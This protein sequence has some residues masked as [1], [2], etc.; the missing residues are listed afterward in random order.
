MGKLAH[1][2]AAGFWAASLL[3]AVELAAIGW[4]SPELAGVWEVQWG[5]LG[6]LPVLVTV[7][8]PLGIVG[9]LCVELL[10]RV[11]RRRARTALSLA[12]AAGACAVA[13]GV[14]GGRLLQTLASRGGFALAVGAAAGLGA[15]LAAPRVARLLGRRPALLAG[16]TA[17]AVLGLE[18]L[19][20]TVFVRRYPAFHLGLAA[21]ALAL[22]PLFARAALAFARPGPPA[23]HGA[24]AALFPAFT[25]FAFGAA[26]ATLPSGAR[27]LSGFDNFRWVLLERAPIAGKL[28]H[29]AGQWSPPAPLAE[30]SDC[31]S[32]P[33]REER[34]ALPRASSLDLSHRDVLLVTIDA[35]RADHVG[36]YGYERPTTPHIDRLAQDG[37]VF[38]Q[39]YVPTPHTSYSLT[40]LMTGKYIRPLLL[41]GAGADSD[42]WAGLLRKYGY[43]T[44]AFYPPA[45]FFIDSSRFEPFSRR[46]HDFEY[47]KVEFAEGERRVAQVRSF[48]TAETPGKRLFVWVHLFGPHEPYEAHAGHDFGTRDIDRYDSEI[49]AADATLGRLVAVARRRDPRALVIVTGDHGEEFG[50]HG[51]RYHGSSVYEEQVRVPLVMNAPGALPASRVTPPV[52]TIDLL[53][54][55]LEALEIPRPPRLRGRD[56]GPLISGGGGNDEGLAISETEEHALLAQGAY[57]LICARKVGAC[58]LFDLERDPQQRR[59]VAD[60]EP[61]RFQQLREKLRRLSASHGRFEASGLRSEGKGWPAAILRGVS[62][63]ADAALEI[64]E[65][66]D[67]ADVAIRRKAAE[68]LFELARPEAAPALRLA[69]QRD[70]DETVRRWA[71]L[72]LTRMGQGAPLVQELLHAEGASWRRL[73]ALAL[74]ETGDRAG[75]SELIEW[76][77]RRGDLEFSRALLLLDALA[78]IRSKDAVWWLIQSLDD[79]RLRPHV[80]RALAKIGERAARGSLLVALRN[81]RYQDTR[82]ALVE[83]LVH[84]GAE[85]ELAPSLVRFLGVPDALRGGL[86]Y[87]VETGITQYVGGPKTRDLAHL[88]T[89]SELGVGMVVVVPPGGNGRGVRAI[90]RGRA[91]GERPALVRIGRRQSMFKYNHKGDVI[92]IRDLPRIDPGGWVEVSLP[93]GPEPV[94]IAADVPESVGAKAGHGIELVV[95]GEREALIDAVALVP[96]ADELPP[97]EPVPWQEGE[98]GR[99]KGEGP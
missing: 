70:E 2:L 53:P 50:D 80:A 81:E 88:R 21:A 41:Q 77:R 63:D 76:W 68:L 37:V 12:T 3:A 94:E 39:A 69:L 42:T 49:A 34:A 19:N 86:G 59:D 5:T 46:H 44:A 38:E 74:A 17:G 84:L 91:R 40:S 60:A 61:K 54:T 16:A 32:E 95:F 71:A 85:E 11:E 24:R 15:W 98:E 66:L 48:V 89:Q 6:L 75:E 83:A 7:C 56:L 62:G 58:R 90:V 43:R 72:T 22:A 23:S 57:R 4:F 29:F 25:L 79:V 8:G 28:V 1:G 99:G 13:W 82:A 47:S 55:L 45:V 9:A 51:G 10:D 52:Q 65:L 18:I 87:A 35:L 31:A 33:C 93:P 67:D 14:G 97:P 36:A 92:K 27:A 78:S 73:A 26:S 20:A 96:L 64:T 30:D